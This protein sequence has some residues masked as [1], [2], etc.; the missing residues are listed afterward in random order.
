MG[1]VRQNQHAILCHL[2]TVL[3]IVCL[4]VEQIVRALNVSQSLDE[5][6]VHLLDL[7]HRILH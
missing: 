7:E 5:S 6:L 3:D 2:A 4:R 1:Q